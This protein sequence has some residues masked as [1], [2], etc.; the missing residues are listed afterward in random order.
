MQATPTNVEA[1]QATAVKAIQVPVVMMR[2]LSS[3][4]VPRMSFA[5]MFSGMKSVFRKLRT[6]AEPVRTILDVRPPFFQA[7]VGSARR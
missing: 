7:C 6:P 1:A 4:S 2:V 3:V 5:A